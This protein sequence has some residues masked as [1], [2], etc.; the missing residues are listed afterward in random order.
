MGTASYI[1]KGTETAM[2]K[3]FG[4]SAHGA[5][6]AMSR[7]GALDEFRGND[8]IK[9]LA[10]KGIVSKSPSPKSMAE[11]A[12]DAYKDVEEVIESVHGS[13]ISLKVIRM[14]P[15]GVLKG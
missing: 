5:G 8:V 12:P 9:E 10:A 11:E 2:Q 14:E 15:I 7:H 13:G 3:T 6:R 4:S 1:L